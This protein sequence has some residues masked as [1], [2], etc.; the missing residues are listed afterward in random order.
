MK[1]SKLLLLKIVKFFVR[2]KSKL[3]AMCDWRDTDLTV[4]EHI[5]SI[6]PFAWAE[7]REYIGPLPLSV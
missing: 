2:I 6:M 5:V 3:K 4:R 7:V 1:F